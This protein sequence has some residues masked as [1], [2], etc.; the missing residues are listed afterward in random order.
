MRAV[1]R[2]LGLTLVMTVACLSATAAAAEM[3]F[4]TASH[5]GTSGDSRI[6]ADREFLKNEGIR[7]GA[8]YEVHLHSPG[9][10][11]I[12]SIELGKMIRDYGFGTRVARSVPLPWSR[13][14]L[15]FESDEEGWPAAD[16]VD[17]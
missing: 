16:L 11:L 15:I 8:R 9:G 2:A 6:V 17:T 7:R 10:N 4:R 12:A 5:G 14:S 13:P 3:E 1:L